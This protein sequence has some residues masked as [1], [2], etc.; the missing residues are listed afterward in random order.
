MSTL[1]KLHVN[2]KTSSITCYSFAI[3]EIPVNDGSFTHQIE[4]FGVSKADFEQLQEASHFE[5]PN[6]SEKRWIISE[7]NPAEVANSFV[8]SNSEL[9]DLLVLAR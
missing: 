9:L 3:N 7:Y 4:F 6:F 1:I 5:L 8:I 2:E